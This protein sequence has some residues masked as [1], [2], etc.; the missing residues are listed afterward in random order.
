MASCAG[1]V[2]LIIDEVPVIEAVAA[3]VA[4]IVQLPASNSA[5]KVP[6]PFTSV[7]FPGRRACASVLVKCTVPE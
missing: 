7:E 5:E 3:A 4:E 6:V 1:A 2:T